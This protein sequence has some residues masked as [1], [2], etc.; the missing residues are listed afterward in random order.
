M[1]GGRKPAAP[2]GERAAP[3]KAEREGL[4]RASGLGGAAPGGIWERE[5]EEEAAPKA[6]AKAASKAPAAA[7][8][9]PPP[10]ALPLG[11]NRPATAPGGVII[12]E[13]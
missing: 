2:A 12:I 4:R 6:S 13:C 1:E 9:P 8:A 7:A 3:T 10:L 11:L 5:E